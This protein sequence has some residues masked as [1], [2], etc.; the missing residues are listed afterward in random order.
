MRLP[1]APVLGVGDGALELWKAVR[2]V[3]PATREQR[4]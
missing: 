3:F 4:C 2:E 1:N